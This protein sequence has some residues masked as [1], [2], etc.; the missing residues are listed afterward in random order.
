MSSL[1]REL[2]GA[3]MVFDLAAETGEMG[4]LEPGHH[5]ARTL[6]KSG[7]LRL[8]LITL[9]PGGSLPEHASAGPISVQ[10]LRGTVQFQID[11]AVHDLAP[12]RL[13]ALGARVRHSATSRDGATLLLTVAMPDT[14]L[15]EPR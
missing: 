1:E 13:L 10:P 4:E 15:P 5:T 14:S 3:A 11:G 7:P 6:H 8:T 12:G 2:D 9:A